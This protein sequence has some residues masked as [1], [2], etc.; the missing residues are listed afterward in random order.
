MSTMYDDPPF[1]LGQ[2]GGISGPTDVLVA[3]SAPA[4]SDFYGIIKLFP[5]VNPITGRVR[6]NRVKKCLAVKNT[7][8][9]T[10]A[11]KRLV[12]LKAGSLFEVDGYGF[13]TDGVTS[14]VVDEYLTA[15]VPNG[16]VFWITIDGPTEVALG[17][18]SQAAADTDLVALTSAASTDA[19]TAGR[20]QTASVT[21]V[22]QHRS[23][24]GRALSASA[25]TA[26]DILASVFFSRR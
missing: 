12:T 11:A 16:E 2:L 26:A 13:R 20:A 21:T 24:F 3:S 17:L 22:G 23:T 10:L 7:S 9:I 25:T 14:G 8:G 6:S 5:D 15:G 1:P 4:G 19:S 18:A